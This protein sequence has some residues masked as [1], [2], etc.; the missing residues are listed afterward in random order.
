VIP[1]PDG[2]DSGGFWEGRLFFQM[3]TDLAIFDLRFLICDFNP[4]SK[5]QNPK[6]RSAFSIYK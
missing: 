5:I 2:N 1:S 3:F 6:F 4:K